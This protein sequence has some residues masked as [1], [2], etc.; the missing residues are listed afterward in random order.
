MESDVSKSCA[1]LLYQAVSLK[2][3]SV[4]FCTYLS[5]CKHKG[6]ICRAY[7]FQLEIPYLV[8]GL[9]V[10]FLCDLS[11]S[12]TSVKLPPQ[13]LAFEKLPLTYWDPGQ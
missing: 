3:S 11:K 13:T 12:K 5:I 8:E 1:F 10:G 6:N 7:F 2:H 9:E 4:L